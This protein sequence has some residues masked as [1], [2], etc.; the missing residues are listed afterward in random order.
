MRGEKVFAVYLYSRETAGERL[1]HYVIM[2][3]EARVRRRVRMWLAQ[4]Q[5]RARVVC[6]GRE[7][8]LLPPHICLAGAESH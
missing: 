8:M 7:V 4:P 5:R 3:N 1:R 6:L 2:R